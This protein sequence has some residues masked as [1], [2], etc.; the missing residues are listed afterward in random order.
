MSELYDS[1]AT[2][3]TGLIC[4]VYLPAGVHRCLQTNSVRLLLAAVDEDRAG[5]VRDETG[6][7]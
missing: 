2:I 1:T 5:I 6:P 7:E 3:T 4:G